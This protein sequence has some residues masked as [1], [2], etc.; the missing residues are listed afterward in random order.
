MIISRINEYQS[1]FQKLI[2]KNYTHLE[3]SDILMIMALGGLTVLNSN[4][5]YDSKT[6]TALRISAELCYIAL[7][8]DE[9]FAEY[10]LQ[11]QKFIDD[12]KKAQEVSAIGQEAGDSNRIS[13]T[14]QLS[15]EAGTHDSE[16]RD[17]PPE[18]IKEGHNGV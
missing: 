16:H 5:E 8:S 1:L 10:S 13:G 4:P 11:R 3:H 12:R 14:D 15:D 17:S 6:R 18:A 9:E 2:K 7:L